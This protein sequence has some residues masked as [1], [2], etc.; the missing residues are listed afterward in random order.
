MNESVQLWERSCS[1]V[2]LIALNLLPDGKETKRLCPGWVGP[3][4]MLLAFLHRWLPCTISISKAQFLWFPEQFLPPGPVFR[5]AAA[6]KVAQELGGGSPICSS[7]FKKSLCWASFT[8]WD[9][10]KDH[11]NS[12]Y[13]NSQES[14]CRQLCV[15]SLHLFTIYMEKGMGHLPGSPTSKMISLVLV[16]FRTRLLYMHHSARYW[17]SSLHQRHESHYSRVIS[18]LYYSVNECVG[19]QSWVYC[20]KHRYNKYS[21]M[22]RFLCHLLSVCNL[23]LDL[24]GIEVLQHI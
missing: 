5:G 9:V 4:L 23:L 7:F 24:G 17:T 19:V 21:E 11:K 1:S 18:E 20:N 6:L 14:P 10:L 12:C 22:G 2:C 13:V 8:R 16:V 3:F 15:H